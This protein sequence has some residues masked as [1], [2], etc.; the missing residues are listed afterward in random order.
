MDGCLAH[1]VERGLGV[2]EKR[3]DQAVETQN[4]G[5]NE[6]QDHADEKSWL[7]SSSTDTSVTD[8]TNGETGGQ[9][10]EADGET[11]TELDETSEETV[12]LLL[13]VVGNQDGDDEAVDTNDTSHNDGHD[14]LDD[15]VGP[16]D[17]HGGNADTRLGSAV[18]GTQAGEDNGCGAAHGTKEGRICG[19]KIR[20]HGG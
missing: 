3:D 12:V 15:E 2:H 18:G 8:D 10:S 4:F 19:A 5:E 14:V 1:D 17:T 13:K 20:R 6:N 16:E 7:L 9:T 11:G